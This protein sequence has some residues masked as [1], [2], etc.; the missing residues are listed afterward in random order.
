MSC[1]TADMESCDKKCKCVGG[2]CAGTAYDCYDP[3]LPDEDWIPSECRCQPQTSAVWEWT[4]TLTRTGFGSTDSIGDGTFPAR[5]STKLRTP[6]GGFPVLFSP[7]C[8]GGTCPVDELLTDTGDPG[9]CG[10]NPFWWQGIGDD[11]A[12]INAAIVGIAQN[13]SFSMTKPTI[14]KS[15]GGVWGP[16]DWFFCDGNIGSA[17]SRKSDGS[18]A[19]NGDVLSCQGVGTSTSASVQYFNGS[20]WTNSG[21]FDLN[22]PTY[23]PLESSIIVSGTWTRLQDC[24]QA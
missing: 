11:N 21:G 19:F 5:L 16:E 2:P 8:T 17:S 13:A 14:E 6:I 23:S 3:C 22:A 24:T 1:P 12:L 10:P 18:R 9:A 20:I 4:G 7:G 15:G